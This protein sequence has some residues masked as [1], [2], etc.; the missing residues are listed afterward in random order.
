MDIE[1]RRTSLQAT[2]KRYEAAGFSFPDD[3]TR[4]RAKVGIRLNISEHVPDNDTRRRLLGWIWVGKKCQL[5]TTELTDAQVRAIKD[6]LQILPTGIGGQF[7]ISEIAAGELRQMAEMVNYAP[8]QLALPA[9]LVQEAIDMGGQVT[10]ID[11][12]E[13]NDKAKSGYFQ[14]E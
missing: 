3:D 13:A 9:E 8:G 11:D 10:K 12:K 7:T 2:A 4:H 14:F 5:S 1:S 6:W